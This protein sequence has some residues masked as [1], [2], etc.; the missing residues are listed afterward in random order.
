MN[1]AQYPLTKEQPRQLLVHTESRRLQIDW[2]DGSQSLIPF[3]QLRRYC[4]CAWCRKS[5]RIGLDPPEDGIDIQE[6]NLVG[7]AGLQ[8]IFADGHNKGFFSWDYLLRI[9]LGKASA[10]DQVM[11]G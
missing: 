2:H 3:T 1:L 7:D 9:A 10:D 5:G 4:A 8:F 11:A 6:V